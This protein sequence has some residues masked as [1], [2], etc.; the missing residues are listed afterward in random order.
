VV[1]DLQ[2]RLDEHKAKVN[3]E[4]ELVAILCDKAERERKAVTQ[5]NHQLSHK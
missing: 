1:I 4:R 5:V 3:R 2:R